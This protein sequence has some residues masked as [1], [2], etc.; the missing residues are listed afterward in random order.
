MYIFPKPKFVEQ[1]DKIFNTTIEKVSLGSFSYNLLRE[2]ESIFKGKLQ[3]VNEPGI[4]T[5]SFVNNLMVEQQGYL[6]LMKDEQ[7]IIEASTDVG[8]YY[9][10][11]TLKQIFK[12]SPVNCVKIYDYPDLEIR[13]IMLDISR[14]KVP[15]VDTIK[16]LIDV[17]S[18][19]KINH[20]ELYIEG[21]ALEYKKYQDIIPHKNHLKQSE[22]IEIENYAN[23]RY[24]DL[25]PNQNGFGHME[26]WL[27]LDEFKDL[28]ECPDGFTIWGSHRPPTTLNPLDE[29]STE[30][31]KSL[32]DEL[33]PIS[34][35]K[36]FHMNFDEPY[37]LGHGKS[38][39]LCDELSKEDV[40]I[41]YFTPLASYVKSFHKTPMLWGDVL[42]H[43][44]DAIYKLP[45]DVIFVDWGYHK[46]YNFEEHAK[47]LNSLGI[48]YLLAPGTSTWSN[49]TCRYED[50]YTTIQ[51]SAEAAKQYNGLGILTTDWGDI[52]HLQYL[53]FSMPGFILGAC[54]SWGSMNDEELKICLGNL[55]GSS[56]LASI[57]YNLSQYTS[58][59]GEYRDY[60]SRL[61]SSILWAEHVIREKQGLDVYFK[62]IQ[63]NI[64]EKKAV[65]DISKLFNESKEKLKKL[66]NNTI[67]QELSNTI[68]I[69]ETLLELNIFFGEYLNN[70][71][72]EHKLVK[73]SKKL[74]QYAQT[75]YGL[76]CERNLEE[77]YFISIQKIK[78][79]Q[80]ILEM[81]QIKEKSV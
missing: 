17:F 35:S 33:L 70:Q 72:D 42:I 29:R 22:Y 60:G 77:G 50:M 1:Y 28:A 16:Q 58:L 44:K 40:Y 74:D 11:Q 69:L 41:N 24:I 55:L 14:N 51:N 46:A 6:L 26:E 81:I 21:F 39:E 32:Y 12:S 4:K 2:L 30:L 27:A 65:E 73:I 18:S 62:K 23:E 10:V 3:N 13:G 79:V 57:I 64:L 47:M 75:H 38:K 9:A 61:F 59:E 68:F 45:H 7:I 31:V 66:Y 19:L 15:L 76:W 54:C 67:C 8:A 56:D 34:T 78:K 63:N 37:E 48:S 5:I 36:Y 53:P 20:L 71:Y 43:N 52:G 49:F 80:R 25:V